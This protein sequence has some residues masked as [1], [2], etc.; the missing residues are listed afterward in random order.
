MGWVFLV[1]QA[2]W[3]G[4]RGVTKTAPLQRLES[5]RMGAR[6]VVAWKVAARPV[7]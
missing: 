3:P 7:A 6:Q 2:S 5:A 1:T 4:R